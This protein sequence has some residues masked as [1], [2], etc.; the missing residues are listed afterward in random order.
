M[1]SFEYKP[2]AK[3]FNKI[4]MMGPNAL[5]IIDEL[6]GNCS[7]EKG[8]RILDL[9]CG[10]GL[11]SMYLAEKFDAT[12]FATDLWIGATENYERFKSFS[13]E[14]RII[15]I[16]ADAHDLP[17]A[18][19]YFDVVVSIGAY[20][21]F[22]CN[23][24]YLSKHLKPI[25]KTGGKII[26]GMS[27]L[28]HEFTDGVPD[29]LKPYWLPEINF[30]TCDWWKEL[31]SPESEIVIDECFEL[32]CIR[33]AW[34]DWLTCDNPYAKRD[35]AMMAAEGGNYFSLLGIKATKR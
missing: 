31:W 28:Q 11:T 3:D 32:K 6:V 29:E 16:H 4:N 1:S 23:E 30:H 10:T 12:V 21:F 14:D 35:I 24:E 33:E 13:L 2:F 20:D 15:P 17:F 8:I 27:G 7:F 34:A 26:I 19:E 25:V 18:D 22:G 9:G 5:R